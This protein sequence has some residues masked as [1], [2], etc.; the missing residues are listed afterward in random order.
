M[1]EILT[2]NDALA[3]LSRS[4]LP[5]VVTEGS[6]DYRIMRKF[7]ERLADCG[8]DFLPV[9]GKAKVLDTWQRLPQTRRRNTVAIVDLDEWL[10]VGIPDEYIG[11]GLFYTFGYSI[12]NDIFLDADLIGICD[13]HEKADFL[14]ELSIVS[15]RHAREIEHLV[16]QRNFQIADHVSAIINAGDISVSLNNA[17][18]HR[19]HLLERHHGQLL[20]GKTLLQLLVRQSSREG[21]YVKF[22]YKHIY[23]LGATRMGTIFQNLEDN[24]RAYFDA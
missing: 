9:G 4:S 7:E 21:R 19:K 17:E 5:T 3:V 18:M 20:R 23:E 15:A 24:I 11:E 2:A 13:P 14:N 8:I 6:D 1:R 10:Y 12:E 22:G 16:H